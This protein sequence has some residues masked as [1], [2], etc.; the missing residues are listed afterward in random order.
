MITFHCPHLRPEQRSKR[1]QRWFIS[2]IY[3]HVAQRGGYCIG[4]YASLCHGASFIFRVNY[5]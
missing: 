4:M 3:L 2:F 1:L 5:R